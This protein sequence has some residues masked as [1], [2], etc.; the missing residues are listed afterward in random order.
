MQLIIIITMVTMM[1]GSVISPALPIIQQALEIETSKIGL[2]MTAFS[3]PGIIS[4]PITGVMADRFGR[5]KVI[6]PMLLLYS[7]A[8]SFCFFAPNFEV[9]LSL[10]FLSGLGAG[11]LAT[12]SLILIGDLFKDNEQKEAL[13]YRT[14]FG[15]F[16]NG[17]L[18]ILGGVLAVISWEF[19]FLL[20][21]LGIPIS[22]MVMTTLP[23]EKVNNH[24]TIKEYIIEVKRGLSN[25]RTASLLTIA[26]T[27]M[28]INQGIIA[29]FLPIYIS[30]KFGVSAAIIGVI[31][32]MRVISGSLIAFFMGKL[33][34]I[35]KEELLLIFSLILLSI[36]ISFIP[37]VTSVWTMIVPIMVAGFALGIS[38]PAFQSLLISETP[39]ELRASVM[40]ANGITNR[41]GQA[42]GPIIAGAVFTAGGFSSVFYGASLFLLIM[43]IFLTL[44][45]R[46]HLNL[47]SIRNN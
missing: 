33:T 7:I 46:K 43:V 3:L 40:S 44:S 31:I 19:P 37:F 24:T 41:M 1:G 32:S 21:L 9:L 11:S 5:Q 14:S 39:R 38:F 10:R 28:I 45:F 29:T 27:L 18:P 2:L 4:I 13:G 34:K 8:G 26:P 20:F 25:S 22:V 15:N 6:V 36:S 17:I 35:I 30:S 12:L 47:I 42:A 16:F 23:N